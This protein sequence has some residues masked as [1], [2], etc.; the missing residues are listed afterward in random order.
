MEPVRILASAISGYGYYYLKTLFEEI[1]ESRAKLVGVIDPLAD[2]SDFYPKILA[3]GIPVYDDIRQFFLDGHQADL[4]VISSPI[5]YHVDQS[6]T[7]LKFGSNVLVDKPLSGS[8][9]EARELILAKNDTGLF[10]EVGYQWSFSKAIRELKEDLLAGDFGKPLRMKTICLWPR[11]YSYY[12]R[13]DWAGKVLSASGKPVNDSPANNACAH[14]LHNLFFLLGDKMDASAEPDQVSGYC[15]RAYEI[16]NY[17]TVEVKAITNSGAE[18]CFYASHVTE[19][20][21][22]PEFVLE[23]ENAVIEMN[24]ESG[25]I[26]ATWLD[27]RV[28]K[29]GLPDADHQFKKL[30]DAIQLVREP[31]PPLCPPEAALS[32]TKTVEELQKS[33]H[34]IVTFPGDS[35]TFET[36]RRYIPGLGEKMGRDYENWQISSLTPMK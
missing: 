28:R 23:C 5:H 22:N 25:G 11:D 36:S 10:V 21:R 35:I 32:Q 12:N 9:G 33:P 2:K 3:K 26:R 7:A 16:E 29:Y 19:L 6:V 8:V 14:F 18:L 20:A 34:G 30:F 4:T 17:D 1:P 27:G 31:G 24:P 13:N 15:Y